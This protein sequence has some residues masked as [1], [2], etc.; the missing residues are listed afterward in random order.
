MGVDTIQK[1]R[2]EHKY[3]INEKIA[4]E[5]RDFLSSYLDLDPYGATQPNLSYPVHSLYLDSPGM[6]TYQDTINGDRNRYK[7][8]IRFYEKA[9][10]LPVYFEIK[11]RY[12]NVIAKKRAIVKRSAAK[13]LVSGFIPG[14]SGLVDPSAEQLD[15][16]LDF[17]RL[18]NNLQAGPKVHVSYLREAW[19]ADG[20]NKIRVTIDRNVRSEPQ[21]FLSFSTSLRNPRPVFGNNI[22]LELKFTNRF[23]N[24]F[25]ELVQVFGLRQGGAAKYVDGV[26]SLG[27]YQFLRS[28]V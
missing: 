15:A 11:R 13:D 26:T 24:W 27:E 28:Y 8:R 18:T 4:L 10:Y 7:L 2:F 22:I 5:I 6:R 12:D 21:N 3:V 9:D 1:Q 19:I 25:K 20:S 23:P 14:Q 16:L 17:T